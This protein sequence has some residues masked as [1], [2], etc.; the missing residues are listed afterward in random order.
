MHKQTPTEA[1]GGLML[2]RFFLLLAIL[3]GI[4]LSAYRTEYAYFH[5]F[6]DDNAVGA[7]ANSLKRLESLPTNIT[8]ATLAIVAAV[9]LVGTRRRHDAGATTDQVGATMTEQP[10]AVAGRVQTAARAAGRSVG[11]LATARSEGPTK[12]AKS[13]D[14]LI[15]EQEQQPPT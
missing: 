7:T 14:Q 9:L 8:G 11:A 4:G 2:L 3:V 13:L 15:A 5:G 12:P 1:S 6:K 10:G